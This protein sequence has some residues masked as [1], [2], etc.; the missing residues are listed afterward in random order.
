MEYQT[1]GPV[2][3]NV[4]HLQQHLSIAQGHLV[5]HRDVV[6]EVVVVHLHYFGGA[7]G[8]P[9]PDLHLGVGQQLRAVGA[10]A[11]RANLRS[12]QIH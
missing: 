6:E 4:D 10:E 3:G 9:H 7:L 1:G 12:G 8:I 2:R 11:G 5:A